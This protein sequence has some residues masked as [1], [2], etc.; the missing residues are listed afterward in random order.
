MEVVHIGYS[1]YIL[2]EENS[3]SA[4]YEK[5]LYKKRWSDAYFCLWV[6]PANGYIAPFLQEYLMYL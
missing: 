5:Y 1:W 2:L 3:H 6:V 4:P